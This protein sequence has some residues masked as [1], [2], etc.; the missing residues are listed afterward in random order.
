[1]TTSLVTQADRSRGAL[2]DLAWGGVLD[3]PEVAFHAQLLA[4]MI[5]PSR[6]DRAKHVE[7]IPKRVYSMPQPTT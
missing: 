7:R 6:A 4:K 3:C 1:M 5:D 2:P